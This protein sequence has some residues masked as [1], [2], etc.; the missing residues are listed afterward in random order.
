MIGFQRD[1]LWLW[2]LRHPRLFALAGLV[3][4]Q[5]NILWHRNAKIYCVWEHGV[6]NAN[7]RTAE[8]MKILLLLQFVSYSLSVTVDWLR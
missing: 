5:S 7:F 3:Y 2:V 8:R 4:I 1:P 6:N